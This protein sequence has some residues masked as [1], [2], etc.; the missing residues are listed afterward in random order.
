MRFKRERERGKNN[1]ERQRERESE[2]EKERERAR[3]RKR[4]RES[5]E[6]HCTCHVFRIPSNQPILGSNLDTC[7]LEPERSAQP[8]GKRETQQLLGLFVAEKKN[9]MPSCSSARQSRR[10]GRRPKWID[11]EMFKAGYVT[12][13]D[14][15]GSPT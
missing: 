1:G 11:C 15:Q 6:F 5:F 13:L 4:E 12:R 7:R 9:R 14:G 8:L 3:E 2:R 10:A